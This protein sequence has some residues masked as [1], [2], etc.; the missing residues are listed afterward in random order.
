MFYN[1]ELIAAKLRR[2][3]KYLDKYTL[4]TWEELP[5]IDLYMDQVVILLGKYLDFLPADEANGKVVSATAINNYVRMRIVPPPDRRKYSRIHM[6]YLIM[7]CSLKQSISIAY[8]S[9]M[10][11]IGLSEDEV[12][13]IYDGYVQ[14]HRAAADYF[15]RQVKSA[16]SDILYPSEKSDFKVSNFV[17][18]VAVIS[19]LSRLL[20]E[21]IIRLQDT[22]SLPAS[23]VDDTRKPPMIPTIKTGDEL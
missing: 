15:T 13:V 9:R 21:K 22:P 14:Q 20:A 18:S 17:T 16:T 10:I 4:P 6:A 12:R 11:P 3:E 8:I 1:E 5:T 2:W 23:Q 19:G 7:I